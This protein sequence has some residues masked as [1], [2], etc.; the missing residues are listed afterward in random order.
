MRELRTISPSQF[1]KPTKPEGSFASY[2]GMPLTQNAQK[3][4]LATVPVEDL[5]PY[6]FVTRRIEDPV[7]GFQRTLNEHRAL[8]IARYLDNSFGSIPTNIVLSAQSEA[9]LTYDSKK[10]TLRFRRGPKSFLVIDGQHRLFGYALT[11]KRHRVPVAIY[12]GLDRKKEAAIFI[13][14][15]TNQRGVPAALLLDIKHIA[16]M[17]EGAETSLR[18]LFDRLNTDSTSVLNGKLSPSLSVPNKISRVTFNRSVKDII[19]NQVLQNLSEDKSYM[20]I[21]NYFK[22]LGQNLKQPELLYRSAYFEAFCSLFEDVVRLAHAR[23]SNTKLPSLAEV[24]SP[25]SNIQLG[26]VL[27]SGGKTKI[28]KTSIIPVLR[29]AVTNRLDI[30]DDQV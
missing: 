10:K 29:A 8:D 6:C 21:S 11:K 14:V 26:E 24:L 16:D 23:F 27:A 1:I 12:E 20:L 15:N 13:D 9:E 28:T 30:T 22:A 18:K 7:E 2:P 19:V 4:Y 3:F 17:E 25:L 5:F